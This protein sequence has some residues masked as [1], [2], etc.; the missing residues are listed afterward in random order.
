MKF[1]LGTKEGMTQ[2]FDANGVC[3]PATVLKVV[4]ATVTQVKSK[5]SADGYAA[6][7]I[8]SGAQKEHRVGK[9]QKGHLGG[10]FK[11]VK[12]FRPRLN[13]TESA[14]AL[15]K[16]Q[17]LDASVFGVGDIIVVSA[18]SKGKGFQGGVK[19]H[20]FRGGQATHGQKHSEREP[21]SIGATGSHVIK[22]TRMAGRMGS[23]RITVKNLKV[24]Q[25]NKEANVLLVSGAVPGRKGTVV[26]VRNV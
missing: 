15:Q 4:P 16:G 17:Q 26:E 1:I 8:A 20:G 7:Q 13:Y 12:E 23:E 2:V 11:K 3:H 22:G 21:G 25:V 9:A 10:S 14:D 5:D 24:L 18:I 6:V 19:R